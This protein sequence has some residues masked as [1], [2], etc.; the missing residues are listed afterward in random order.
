[1]AA[2]Q[3]SGAN[4]IGEFAA[5]LGS[6]IST[7]I[8]DLAN[9][10]QT[11]N[12]QRSYLS[13]GDGLV[14]TAD[15]LMTGSIGF[16]G[17]QDNGRY[18]LSTYMVQT[19][20]GVTTG[21][22]AIISSVMALA[23]GAKNAF[24]AEFQT[25]LANSPNG[26]VQLTDPVFRGPSGN[27]E[28]FGDVISELYAG[29]PND[30]KTNFSN[31]FGGSTFDVAGFLANGIGGTLPTSFDATSVASF[32]EALSQPNY[33]DPKQVLQSNE[34]VASYMNWEELF[35]G[36]NMGIPVHYA[37]FAGKNFPGIMS[38]CGFDSTDPTQVTAFNAL[39]DQVM[40]GSSQKLYWSPSDLQTLLSR[41]ANFSI[42]AAQANVNQLTTQLQLDNVY[43]ANTL[44]ITI[45]RDQGAI[46]NLLADLSAK[47]ASIT[48]SLSQAMLST[49][50]E[51]VALKNQIQDIQS[52][53]SDDRTVI[54][55]AQNG[56]NELVNSYV[57]SG[58]PL[59][60]TQKLQ[61]AGYQQ[62]I[63][64]ALNH[65]KTS[66]QNLTSLQNQLLA[67]A[68][69]HGN[70]ND[71]IGQL[72]ASSGLDLKQ[73]VEDL[74]GKGPITPIALN[75]LY[76]YINQNQAP[77][78][79]ALPLISDGQLMATAANQLQGLLSQSG[80]VDT[81][82]SGHSVDFSTQLFTFPGQNGNIS[83]SQAI[84][85]IQKGSG[86]NLQGVL[87]TI[88]GNQPL[89]TQN[90]GELQDY[91]NSPL[92]QGQTNVV[93]PVTINGQTITG[94]AA[95]EY[96]FANQLN[97]LDMVAVLQNGAP[98][99]L[100]AQVFN[101]RFFNEILHTAKASGYDFSSILPQG[102]NSLNV[103]DVV[104]MIQRCNADQANPD[105]KVSISSPDALV[106]RV[107]TDAI[108]ASDVSSDPN[109]PAPKAVIDRLRALGFENPEKIFAQA[110]LA[111]FLSGLEGQ[112][113][114][115]SREKM[116]LDALNMYNPFQGPSNL[117]VLLN[118]AKE[119]GISFSQIIPDDAAFVS[120][121]Q[122]NTLFVQLNQA[123]AGTHLVIHN[124]FEQLNLA[125]VPGTIDFTQ[126]VPA[127][128]SGVLNQL[129]QN[130]S[131]R[132]I[133]LA[134]PL[135][136]STP[137]T[138][139]SVSANMQ[140]FTFPSSVLDQLT[141]IASA[142]N[143][144][145]ASDFDANG[146]F[147]VDGAFFSIPSISANPV[148]LRQIFDSAPQNTGIDLSTAM[149]NVM[150]AKSPDG[151]ATINAASVSDLIQLL[152]QSL[153]VGSLRATSLGQII[154]A[155]DVATISPLINVV[156]SADVFMQSLGVLASSNDT[157]KLLNI[158]AYLDSPSVR[159]SGIHSYN[160]AQAGGL[161]SLVDPASAAT[162]DPTDATF[163]A[164]IGT[165][166][167]Q[168][169]IQNYGLTYP[170]Y[171]SPN[172]TGSAR[173]LSG[174]ESNY[175]AGGSWWTGLAQAINRK[176][177]ASS[178]PNTQAVAAILGVNLFD[179][180]QVNGSLAVAL[181]IGIPGSPSAADADSI[182][183][184][185]K[186]RLKG[187]V[188]N[189]TWPASVSQ[190]TPSTLD[191]L[192]QLTQQMLA[193]TNS[194]VGAIN[195]AVAGSQSV[196]DIVD[197]ATNLQNIHFEGVSEAIRTGQATTRVTESATQSVNFR[198]APVLTSAEVNA[199]IAAGDI[200]VS[201]T[202]QFYLNRQ[203]TNPRD[204]SVA[205]IVVGNNKL[206][207]NLNNLMN[208]VNVNN[209][210]IQMATYLSSATSAADLRTRINSQKSQYGY[211]D[212]LKELTGG[213]MS[214]SDITDT[215]DLTPG[216][217]FQGTL[218]TTINNATKNQDLDTQSLQQLTT[219][220]QAN[221]T[222]MTQLIQPLEQMLKGL[223]QN[224]R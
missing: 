77:G 38:L 127:P 146:N 154:T 96:A 119:A 57:N 13:Y 39:L 126:V 94:Q 132:A 76:A 100:D 84:D 59:T 169:L 19:W 72:Q 163:N 165:P 43:V 113:I 128:E 104:G 139:D 44:R 40:P 24:G 93:N 92:A 81:L 122:L 192:K 199:Q 7:V 3:G 50:P 187:L 105:F 131:V 12:L 103:G 80:L 152:N 8:N 206:N 201:R 47:Q 5:N 196:I 46:S 224:L 207:A 217:N 198:S 52:S 120:S 210:H 108:V 190:L 177:A 220:I 42:A 159:L 61:I 171:I 98:F 17:G 91:L 176:V 4:S 182:Y 55:N 175:Y 22:D 68:A 219:Q 85:L 60:D 106:S 29:L 221:N 178:N 21:P 183:Q 191:S 151:T 222:A 218:K 75:Q 223:T 79:P 170:S 95:V 209:T 26:E 69:P 51:A 153:P 134:L 162:N 71:I 211:A 168:D 194:R 35:S 62:Q 193:S 32:T 164:F 203:P 125:P 83:F 140:R 185:V 124:P 25:A 172:S 73:V 213:A 34:R 45:T 48:Q 174:T 87:N 16:G 89:N 110:M 180:T 49:A 14:T 102:T 67:A 2:L 66:Q 6:G 208:K 148:S 28:S 135:S 41:S 141:P 11:H 112:Q 121:D 118:N 215:T 64:N 18:K 31:L 82:S 56:L 136:V 23:V 212:V 184:Q 200:Y 107:L 167:I 129:T 63:S 149:G 78:L 195:D 101:G 116:P 156:A 30:F 90:V 143:Q 65:I 20:E 133:N 111:H 186:D 147:L 214:D 181:G 10:F 88:I 144:L 160:F 179:H 33:T 166:F 37:N 138:P 161:Y 157:Q 74:I 114:A 204:A 109:A 58:T 123:N 70:L 130:F 173:Q 27:L 97:Q 36:D 9:F 53:I 150:P 189:F 99:D 202:G 86:V 158:K 216:S 137:A 155:N 54:T 197:S 142:L 205:A 115:L 188:P 15:A 1:M 117:S 145:K